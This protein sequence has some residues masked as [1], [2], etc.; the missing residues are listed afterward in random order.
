MENQL[1]IEELRRI[2]KIRKFRE[3]VIPVQNLNEAIKSSLKIISGEPIYTIE[4][5]KYGKKEKVKKNYFKGERGELIKGFRVYA[6]AKEFSN[7]NYG[8]TGVNKEMFITS[9]GKCLVFYNS[10]KTFFSGKVILNRELSKNQSLSEEEK[11][12][13]LKNLNLS[14]EFWYRYF[15]EIEERLTSRNNTPINH[16]AIISEVTRIKN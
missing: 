8:T 15:T 12:A 11:E 7:T 3:E 4:S 14:L 2:E 13:I 1:S 16:E 10:F 5:W 6:E 9:E